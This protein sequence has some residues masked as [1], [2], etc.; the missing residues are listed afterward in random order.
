MPSQNESIFRLAKAACLGCFIDQ[1]HISL[2]TIIASKILMRARQ[3]RTSLPFPVFITELCKRAQVP[4]DVKKDVEVMPTASTDIRRIKAEYLKDKAERKKAASMKLVNTK[5]SPA[6]THLSTPTPGPSGISITIV[7]HADS[8]G[9]SVAARSPR[10]TTVAVDSRLPL[11][12]ASLLR[13]GQLAL[14]ADRRAA[15]LEASVL[16]MIQIALTDVVTPLSTTI[17]ALT[18]RIAV[19]EHNQGSTEEV[20]TLKVAI[21]ELQKDIDHM[22]STDVS[23][24][25]GIVETPGMP[26][27]P[28]ITAGHRDGR[29]HTANPEPKAKTDEEMFEEVTTDN[30]TKTE[31]IMMDATVQASLA[32]SP[33][34]GSSGAGP[35]S[36]HSEYRCYDR[37]SNCIAKIPSL[38]PSLFFVIFKNFGFLLLAFE[39]K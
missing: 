5:S 12:R 24:V 14:S 13:M 16:H 31:E 20:T 11:T 27:I 4:R 18:A 19:C 21:A 2:D 33:A 34:A 7:T 22:K 32:K 26:K 6:E 37:W 1:T 30:I 15:N 36:G 3:S 38:P 25:F 8:P 39:E 29:E 9:S 10:P 28:Q 35:S 17:D 23:I